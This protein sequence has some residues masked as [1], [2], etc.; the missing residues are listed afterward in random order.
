MLASWVV[1]DCG[2]H[3]FFFFATF[4][5]ILEPWVGCLPLV[6]KCYRNKEFSESN[7]WG[8][9]RKALNLQLLDVKALAVLSAVVKGQDKLFTNS[10]RHPAVQV[11]GL[12]QKS[13][14][15][16]K[17]SACHIFILS[18]THFWINHVRYCQ[19]LPLFMLPSTLWLC[20]HNL[21]LK[22]LLS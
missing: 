20:F 4:P 3:L 22:V 9:L 8:P 14:L 13:S 2:W 6:Q 5:C 7:W 19:F 12:F 10:E 16:D 1:T 15:C 18:Y 21:V 17:H 11:N